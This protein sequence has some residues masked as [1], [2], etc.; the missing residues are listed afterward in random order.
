VV[1]LSV[2]VDPEN[3]EATYEDGVL[4]IVLPVRLPQAARQV[5]IQR[6]EAEE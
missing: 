2:D 1:E 3:A 6:A 4:R 5:P